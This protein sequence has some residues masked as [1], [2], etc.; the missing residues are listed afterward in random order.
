MYGKDV[1]YDEFELKLAEILAE[2]RTATGRNLKTVQ[3]LE[4]YVI[5]RKFRLKRGKNLRSLKGLNL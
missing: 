3:D 2:Y 5:Q 4:S 1:T